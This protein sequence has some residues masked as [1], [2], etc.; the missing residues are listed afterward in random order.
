MATCI[1]DIFFLS[2]KDAPWQ[3]KLSGTLKQAD[4][5]ASLSTIF[6]SPYGEDDTVFITCMLLL[7]TVLFSPL[8]L[9]IDHECV[10]DRS[11][12]RKQFAS[13]ILTIVKRSAMVRARVLAIESFQSR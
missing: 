4:F 10:V 7:L 3:E 2:Y 5:L 8:Q 1:C 6:K 12:S 9:Y 13:H 11:C